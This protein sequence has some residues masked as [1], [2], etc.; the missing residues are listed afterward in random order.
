ME[1][2]R[3]RDEGR[4]GGGRERIM[5]V[6]PYNSS[7]PGDTDTG[8][9]WCP[10]LIW[11]AVMIQMKTVTTLNQHSWYVCSILLNMHNTRC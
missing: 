7:S 2:R 8:S 3:E 1:G 11:M 5:I 9:L 10:S 4:E 6:S